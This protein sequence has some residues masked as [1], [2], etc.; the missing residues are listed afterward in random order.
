MNM[1]YCQECGSKIKEASKNHEENKIIVGNDTKRKFLK[2][3]GILTIIAASLCFI[4]AII[5]LVA[6]TNE[7]YTPGVY[8][9]YS[10]YPQYQY[11]YQEYLPQYGLTAAFGFFAFFLGLISGIL[12]LLRKLHSLTL[13][14]IVGMMGAAILLV[15]VQWWF[16]VLL[17]VPILVLTILS[18]VF[19][20]I[21]KSEFV[22]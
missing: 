19:T 2:A 22:S 20:A 14:G 9:Y 15:I 12:I 8:D 3:A 10:T 16:F 1:K 11:S 21:S 5:G 4:V 18:M 13:F 6:Y 7:V 17:G